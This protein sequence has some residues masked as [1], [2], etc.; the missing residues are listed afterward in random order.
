MKALEVDRGRRYE[1]ALALADDLQ[2]YLRQEPVTA[3]P[4]TLQYQFSKFVRRHRVQVVAASVAILALVVG[5]IAA[6]VGMVRAT[7][8]EATARAGGRDIQTGVRFSGAAV[9]ALESG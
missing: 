3:R 6:G 2:R 4:P 1:T 8:A 9:H 7:R 5:A